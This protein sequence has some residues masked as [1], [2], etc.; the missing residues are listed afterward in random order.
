MWNTDWTQERPL[1]NKKKLSW[2]IR[3]L[4]QLSNQ[5]GM[6]FFK[7]PFLEGAAL[8]KCVDIN[9]SPS[10]NAASALMRSICMEK[11]MKRESRIG[12]EKSRLEAFGERGY[13]WG[14][15]GFSPM[16]PSSHPSS[17]KTEVMLKEDY[18][19]LNNIHALWPLIPLLKLQ[20][21]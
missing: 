8:G 10:D 18:N 7:Y 21:K 3:F 17:F 16:T 9:S 19:D 1:L 4:P 15:G 11:I 6:E 12:R 14:R 5:S 13:E 20:S 2:N